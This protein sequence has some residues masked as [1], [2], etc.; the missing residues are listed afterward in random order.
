V[1][2]TRRQFGLLAMAAAG[3]A[4]PQ[5][6]YVCPMHPEVRRPGAGK[7]PLCG[8]ALISKILEPSEYPVE[9][10]FTPPRFRR[11]SR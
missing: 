8:M 6:Q 7:C 3:R 2:I 5:D 11:V 1:K 10:S 4:E 9:F